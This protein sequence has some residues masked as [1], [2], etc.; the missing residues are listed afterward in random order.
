MVCRRFPSAAARFRAQIMSCGICGGQSNTGASFLRVL[1]FPLT[2]VIHLS[3][4]AGTIGQLV[5][6][7]LSGLSL[8]PPHPKKLK[9]SLLN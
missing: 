1:R 7:L 8:T 5:A 2:I 3:F 9:K 6:K 4:G